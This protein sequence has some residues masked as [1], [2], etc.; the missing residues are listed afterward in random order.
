VTAG[1]RR[2][3]ETTSLVGREPVSKSHTQLPDTL[4]ASYPGGEFRTEQAS[5]CGFVGEPS[6]GSEPS[7]DGSRREV[8]IFKEDAITNNDNIVERQSRFGAV[9]LNEFIDG[10]SVSPL[11]LA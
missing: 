10:M 6:H 5:I 9:P 2:L 7:I 1:R 8:A 3:P 11:R 4:H